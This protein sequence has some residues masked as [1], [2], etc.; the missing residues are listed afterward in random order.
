[1]IGVGFSINDII[2]DVLSEIDIINIE[3]PLY[4]N[5]LNSDYNADVESFLK[6]NYGKAIITD[7]SYIDL[8]P[9][10][11]EKDIKKIVMSKVQQSIDFATS[12]GSDE[13]IFLSTFLPMIG[14]DFYDNGHIDNSISFWKEITESNK[15]ITISLCNIF[16]YNPN[17]LLEIVKGVN[18]S[19]F[20]LA[21][22]V[23]HAFAY[24]KITLK[25][26]YESMEPYCKS[27]YLHS[28]RK[29]AD[30][31]LDIF[32]GELLR[33]GQLKKFIPLLRGKN[34]IFKLFDK[35]RVRENIDILKHLLSL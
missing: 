5:Y 14:I 8:N 35:T 13:V 32:E 18:H 19:N 24:G 30:E 27:V 9:G 16:E 33:S 25:E 21:F 7:G 28:N 20:G 26:F 31:H 34:I 4:P 10:T 29:N 22:D 2:D 11:P 15:N 12:V 1:M 17:V 6:E 3:N 23:G